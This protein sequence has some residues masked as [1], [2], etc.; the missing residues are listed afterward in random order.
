MLGGRHERIHPA[1]TTLSQA[2]LMLRSA[3][4]PRLQK[5]SRLVNWKHYFNWGKIWETKYV[6]KSCSNCRKCTTCTFAGSSI[7]QK[8]RIQ[9]EYIERGIS[10]DSVRKVFNV[11]YPFMEDPREALTD[12]RRQA[13]AYAM[14]LEKK[15]EKHNLKPGFDEELQKFLDTKSLREISE[16]EQRRWGGT[17]T[18]CA[19]PA[20]CESR[21]TVNSTT[22]SD[23]HKLQRPSDR[24]E[25]Q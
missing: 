13:V 4:S 16:E 7:T 23:N 17:C 9:L 24:Q 21:L 10:H 12:N 19:T 25:P 3:S 8:E 18:L 6:P 5:G 11:E 14:S 2:C 22:H 20:C 1:V 15:L